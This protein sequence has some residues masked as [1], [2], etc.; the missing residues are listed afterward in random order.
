MPEIV[1]Q[2]AASLVWAQLFVATMFLLALYLT[3]LA[4]RS[5]RS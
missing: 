5:G 3:I 4:A 2:S 1:H